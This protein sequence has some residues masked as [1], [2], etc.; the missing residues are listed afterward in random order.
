MAPFVGTP[1]ERWSPL[2]FNV[3]ALVLASAL[4]ARAMAVSGMGRFGI[5][6][7]ALAPLALATYVTAF[8]GMENAL[9]VAASLATVLGLW[10]F[11]QTGK[12]G[13]LLLVGIV[14][15]SALRLE[16]LALGL[17]VAGVA[18]LIGRTRVAVVLATLAIAPVLA[19]AAYL[20]GMG[21]DPLPNSIAAKMQDTG[22]GGPI[23]KFGLNIRTYGGRY[24]FALSAVVLLVSLVEYRRDRRVGLVGLAVAGA[25]FAHLAFGSTGWLD[26]YETYANVLARRRTG[27]APFPLPNRWCGKSRFH[28]HCSAGFGPIRPTRFLSMLGT[29]LRSRRNT[30]N[31]RGWRQIM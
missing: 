30:R 13:L 2:I 11:A 27:P 17:A 16:G 12:V 10:T 24:L 4:F 3:V 6:L 23:A 29:R 1:L 28:S 22:A 19:F 20:I 5:I 31:W 18:A 21:L 9:H 15:A 26:R 8:A 14:L 7:S 25:G